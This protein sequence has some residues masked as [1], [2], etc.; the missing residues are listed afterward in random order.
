MSAALALLLVPIHVPTTPADLARLMPSECVAYIETPALGRFLARRAD[1]PVCQALAASPLARVIEEKLDDELRTNLERLERVLGGSVADGIAGLIQGGAAVGFVRG[2]RQ[3]GFV[4]CLAAC[5]AETASSSLDRA[6]DEIAA[7]SGMARASFA[8]HDEEDGARVWYFGPIA[9]A[10]RSELILFASSPGLM[11]DALER[12][13]GDDD[14]SLAGDEKFARV[15]ART[16]SNDLAWGWAD[17]EALRQVRDDHA[18]HG[19]PLTA[20]EELARAPEAHLILG[21][22]FARIGGAEQALFSVRIQASQLALELEGVGIDELAPF[23]EARGAIVPLART[24]DDTCLDALVYRDLGA[25][26]AGASASFAS[27]NA[28]SIARGF[29]ELSVLFG[30]ID[31]GGELLPKI[32]PWMRL[33]SRPARFDGNAPQIELPAAAWVLELEDAERTGPLLMSAFQTTLAIFNADRAQNQLAPFMLAL[34]REGDVEISAGRPLAPRAGEALDVSYNLA[35]A[36][37]RVGNY[38]VL[39]T[40][41]SLVHELVRE[42]PGAPSGARAASERV[43]LSAPALRPYLDKNRAALVAHHQLE[44]GGDTAE[45]EVAISTLIEAVRALS[46]LGIDV[47]TPSAGRLSLRATL[48]LAPAGERR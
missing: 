10:Q 47:S 43:V 13:S 4:A 16:P 23:P 22:R 14:E 24:R 35:P 19:G 2:V 15:H 20:L 34:E 41:A 39:G 32:K 40:H 38:F 28:A 6:F 46:R 26:T 29:D 42:L 17:L 30:G 7:V 1:E 27:E 44:E 12:A 5:D 31:V 11:R 3:P 9:L 37:A 45:A 48:E 18:P 8:P 36:C 21:E 25:F 33:V